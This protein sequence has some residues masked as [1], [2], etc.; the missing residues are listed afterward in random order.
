MLW[1]PARAHGVFGG[2]FIGMT[3]ACVAKTVRQD[4]TLHSLRCYFLLA[5][6]RSVHIIYRVNRIRH[7]SSHATRQMD[8]QQN[9]RCFF[10]L[11]LSYWVPEP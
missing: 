10:T 1:Q 6:N 9:G 11:L 7:G 5:G 8:M 2:Q 4:M 3:V